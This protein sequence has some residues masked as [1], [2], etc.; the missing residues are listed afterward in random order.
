[1]RGATVAESRFLLLTPPEDEPE[2]P[3]L[4]AVEIK[5]PPLPSMTTEQGQ[6]MKPSGQEQRIKAVTGNELRTA[7]LFPPFR[8]Y[9]RNPKDAIEKRRFEKIGN[10]PGR[11]DGRIDPAIPEEVI[12]YM[13]N[14]SDMLEDNIKSFT[15]GRD[16]VVPSNKKSAWTATDLY[17]YMTYRPE[18]YKF[19]WKKKTPAGTSAA[20]ATKKKTTAGVAGGAASK[21]RSNSKTRTGN[22]DKGDDTKINVNHLRVLAND[23]NRT[24][25]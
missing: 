15:T 9:S 14:M 11:L 3:I 10:I 13:T 17:Q 6:M 19:S 22:Q 7:K 20:G 21:K 1:M 16:S 18:E 8:E 12:D 23:L 25:F 2:E 5:T 4:A 24:E